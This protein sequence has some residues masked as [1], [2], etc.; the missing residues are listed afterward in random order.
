VNVQ[1]LDRKYVARLDVCHRD[2][3]GERI[4]AV[5]VEFSEGVRGGIGPYLSIR[6]L[7]GAVDDREHRLLLIVKRNSRPKRSAS[8]TKRSW[9]V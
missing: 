4:E 8:H 2:G 9:S 1:D 5:P 3:A 6:D 7:A